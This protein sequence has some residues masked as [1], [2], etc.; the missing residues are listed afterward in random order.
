MLLVFYSSINFADIIVRELGVKDDEP[1]P[2]VLPYGFVSEAMGA[3]VGVAGGIS[4]FPQEQNSLIATA[5]VSNEGAAAVYVFF[6]NY[7]FTTNTHL[8]M[9]I[10]LGLGEFPQQRAYLDTSPPGN[11]PPAG[12]NDSFPD[13]YFE[14]EGFSNWIEI[15]FKY[16]FNI[17]NAQSNPINTYTLSEGL[18][19]GGGKWW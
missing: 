2:F 3:V 5:L 14:V 19:V 7:Q 16:I 13:N 9:D 4:G 11:S 17:G 15:D 1:E 6:N 12:S 8:F 10:S 18:L